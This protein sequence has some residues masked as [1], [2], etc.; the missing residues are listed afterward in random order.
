VLLQ[1][2]HIPMDS[3]SAALRDA[4]EI[5][6]KAIFCCAD[7]TTMGRI[8]FRRSDLLMNDTLRRLLSALRTSAG[9]VAISM[10]V[11][12]QFKE[13]GPAPFPPAEAHQKIRALLDQVDAT[14][15]QQTVKILTGWLDWYRDVADE[16]LIT[17]WKGDKRTNL[18]LVMDEL[19]D[20]R[21]A[22]EIVR[23]WRQPGLNRADAPILSKLMAR[24]TDSAEPFLH[25]VLQ[26]PD[27]SRPETEAVCRILLDMPEQFRGGALQ[28]LP[29]YRNTAQSLLAQDLRA[30][31]Q[32]TM[33]RAQF[34]LRGLKWDVPGET[35]T[36]QAPVRRQTPT[37][38]TS[39]DPAPSRPRLTTAVPR[40]RKR[41][42]RLV[43]WHCHRRL[44]TARGPAP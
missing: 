38:M 42:K 40:R 15:R 9:L 3:R 23:S 29:H 6:P 12:A 44:T 10:M 24:Y 5:W 27:L 18:N 31:D 13:I 14:N 22:S 21:I 41:P 26:T 2:Q 7:R 1:A 11:Y 33:G 39:A 8:Y 28:I 17:T 36:Q 34:W 19:G 30:S 37:P 25:D 4:D 43:N 20:P 35:S 32:E 16:E